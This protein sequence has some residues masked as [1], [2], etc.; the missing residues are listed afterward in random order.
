VDPVAH[1][2]AALVEAGCYEV[3]LG[4]TIGVGTPRTTAE[5]LQSCARS[6]PMAQLAGHFHDTYGM[7][8]ANAAEALRHGMT[9]FDA[10]VS[11]LGGCP[12][13][14]GATGN[15]ATEDLVYLLH[16]LGHDTGLSLERLME[17]S[18][19]I[20][21]RLGRQ[22]ASRVAAAS[23]QRLACDFLMKPGS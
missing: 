11:G 22:T 7:A 1:L 9:T 14:P 15:V 16:G 6:M 17:A 23:R 4:D 10:S 12:Y 2:A 5:L 19:F 13:A 20:C 21:E 3:S 8:I 18:D